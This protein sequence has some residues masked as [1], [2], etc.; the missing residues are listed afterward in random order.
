[1]TFAVD[2]A[3]PHGQFDAACPY[4]CGDLNK[5]AVIDLGMAFQAF[6]ARHGNGSRR[7]P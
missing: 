2:N 4:R 7:D 3:R 1:M 6:F 5:E